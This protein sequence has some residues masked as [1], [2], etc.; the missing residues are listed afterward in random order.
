MKEPNRKSVKPFSATSFCDIHPA[1]PKQHGMLGAQAFKRVSAV[2]RKNKLKCQRHEPVVYESVC[3]FNGLLKAEG[4]GLRAPCACVLTGDWGRRCFPAGV[5]LRLHPNCPGTSP[6]YAA[7]TETAP[8]SLSSLY[9]KHGL[10]LP[11]PI[12]IANFTA[13]FTTEGNA[14]YLSPSAPCYH[15]TAG[16][17]NKEHRKP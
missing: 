14:P 5:S 3:P 11:P 1:L 9:K 2:L 7:G 6:R 10:F 15:V 16:N 4:R 8:F 13:D 17:S 12:F